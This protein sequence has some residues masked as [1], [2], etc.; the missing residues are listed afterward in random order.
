IGG[1][2]KADVKTLLKNDSGF[3]ALTKGEPGTPGTNGTN[4]KDGNDGFS[5]YINSDNK[6]VV[7][8]GVTNVLAKGV[9]GKNGTD[10]ATFTP[11]VDASGNLSWSNNKGL[12]NPATKNI[13][14]APGA[15]G[16]T[17]RPK[18]ADGKITWEKSD[19]TTVAAFDV[20][21]PTILDAKGYQ[22]AANV[23]SIVDAKGYLTQSGVDGRVKNLVPEWARATS[24]PKYTAAEVGV[25]LADGKITIGTSSITPVTSLSGYATQSWVNGKGFQTEANV[26]TIINGKGFATTANVQYWGGVGNIG[27]SQTSCTTAQFIQQ[28]K[29]LGAFSHRSWAYKCSWDYANSWII[30]DTGCGNIQLAGCLIEVMSQNE[31]AYMIRV[32]TSPTVDTTLGAIANAVFVYRNHGSSYYPNWQRVGT[33]A[34]IDAKTDLATV[35]ANCYV[36][37]E[38]DTKVTTLNTAIGK[39]LNSS[40]FTFAKISGTASDAQIPNLNASKITA[41][42]LGADRI[43]NLNAS[44]I[45]AGTLVAE[46]IPTLPIAKVSNL[47]T[48]LDGK[49]T[50]AQVEGKG[51]QT[52][53]QVNTAITNGVPA[54][55]RASAK[56]TYAYTEITGRITKVS[57]LS[58]D[59]GYQTSSQV[60]TI[61]NGKGFATTSALNSGLAGKADSSDVSPR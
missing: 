55:A 1:L 13:K 22:T 56:P 2:I 37:T 27:G 25:S 5:P 23:N 31:N 24:K 35:K 43:P 49:C 39:K 57:E 6:W 17:W 59:S 34:E 58:N 30:T 61:I 40:D 16:D 8:S 7:K 12:T 15:K 45:T 52:L 33:K 18:I 4:G 46:R 53:A 36:K 51:Y 41:G 29:N 21:T 11:S 48:T 50:L 44:K 60:N 38:I 10:G 54:W 32:T 26:N 28:L 47:Q 20:V 42:T 3:V 9:D 14:G 19:A